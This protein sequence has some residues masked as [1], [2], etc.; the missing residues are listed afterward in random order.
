MLW[1]LKRQVCK[2]KESR[3]T[4]RVLSWS[5][6][7]TDT[8]NILYLQLHKTGSSSWFPPHANVPF[9]EHLSWPPLIQL[10]VLSLIFFS[11]LTKYLKFSLSF[12]FNSWSSEF[13]DC[14][15]NPNRI[16][17]M[18]TWLIAASSVPNSEPRWWD[19]VDKYSLNEAWMVWDKLNKAAVSLAWFFSEPWIRQSAN[20]W[21]NIDYLVQTLC[22]SLRKQNW[23][24]KVQCAP[25]W[26][27]QHPGGVQ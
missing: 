1:R 9:L 3:M 4:L 25:P 26:S 11:G 12:Y 5:S 24:Q 14:N 2:G 23:A 16:R 15:A 8:G 13:P 22:Q 20:Q 27:S 21:N 19:M 6:T 7:F 10:R 17:T 18:S